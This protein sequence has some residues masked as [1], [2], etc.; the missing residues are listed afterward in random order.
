MII[1]VTEASHNTIYVPLK[2][3]EVKLNRSGVSIDNENLDVELLQLLYQSYYN[4]KFSKLAQKPPKER[5][6]VT[7]FDDFNLFRRAEGEGDG[8]GGSMPAPLPGGDCGAST[9]AVSSADGRPTT[10]SCSELFFSNRSGG[11]EL[12]LAT[13][14]SDSVASRAVKQKFVTSSDEHI[15]RVTST[16]TTVLNTTDG[17]V[18]ENDGKREMS[19]TPASAS[20]PTVQRRV[21]EIS[22]QTM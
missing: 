15:G 9:T 20:T 10:A 3:V 13:V 4:S 7:Y 6:R 17:S 19:Q 11:G 16:A 22:T 2:N 12:S 5:L 8:D 21:E 18:K 1:K 14:E